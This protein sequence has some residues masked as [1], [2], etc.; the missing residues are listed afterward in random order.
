VKLLKIG[1]ERSG[2]SP[3]NEYARR[4]LKNIETPQAK[5]LLK[6]LADQRG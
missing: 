6:D 2:K 4:V 1:S 3:R 5:A